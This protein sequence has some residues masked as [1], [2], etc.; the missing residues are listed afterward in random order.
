MK[1]AVISNLCQQQ[2]LNVQLQIYNNIVTKKLFPNIKSLNLTIA[3]S[4]II[5]YVR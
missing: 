5:I 1:F 3:L 4:V 2:K